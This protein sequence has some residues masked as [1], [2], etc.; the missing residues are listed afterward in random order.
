MEEWL[1]E[2]CQGEWSLSLEEMDDAL[3]K[4]SYRL[5]FE[6]EG[7]KRSFVEDFTRRR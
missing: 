4:T 5:M 2:K 1:D 7:D 3:E 6:I